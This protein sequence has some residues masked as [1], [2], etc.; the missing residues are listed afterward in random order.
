MSKAAA[1]E[2]NPFAPPIAASPINP[3]TTLRKIDLFED[4]MA[5]IGWSK[6]I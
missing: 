2:K 3:P 1:P 6:R 5:R 4:I